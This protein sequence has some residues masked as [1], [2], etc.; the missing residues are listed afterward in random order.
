MAPKQGTKNHGALSINQ[1]RSFGPSPSKMAVGV[2]SAGAFEAHGTAILPD[3]D[4]RQGIRTAVT[5]C[6]QAGFAYRGHIPYSSDR[7][8]EV[9]RDWNGNYVGMAKMTKLVERF[10]RNDIEVYK[11]HGIP[12]SYAVVISGHGGNNFLK[13]KEAK[14]SKAIRIPF[15]YVAPFDGV[16]VKSARH[17]VVRITHADLAEHSIALYLNAL[18]KRK[19][20]RINAV[21]KRDPLEALRQN[22]AIMGLGFYCLPELGGK[23]YNKLRKSK[24]F[25]NTTEAEKFKRNR[26][27]EADYEIGRQFIQKNVKSARKR[28][29]EFLKTQ[30]D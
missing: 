7:A 22:T 10:I 11:R 29:E 26:K 8:G 15:L 9:A 20:A 4:N 14:I 16:S 17:G 13:D 5:V 18:D 30:E 12:T 25:S 1:L 28:I 6:E 21:A 27:V 24:F 3:I 2:Y 19:L 23:R